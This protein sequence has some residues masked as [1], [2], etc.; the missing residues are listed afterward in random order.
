MDGLGV[1][2]KE[3]MTRRTDRFIMSSQR[4]EGQ[5][6]GRSHASESVLHTVKVSGTELMAFVRARCWPQSKPRLTESTSPHDR[7]RIP[8][9]AGARKGLPTWRKQ[10]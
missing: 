10:Q 6:G 9:T 1:A 4:Y 7:L 3:S 8:A 5:R 2:K